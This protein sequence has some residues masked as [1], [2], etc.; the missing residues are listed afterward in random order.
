MS[1]FGTDESATHAL[2]CLRLATSRSPGS[3]GAPLRPSRRVDAALAA[4]YPFLTYY[5]QETR[6]YALVALLGMLV[7]AFVLTFV[8]GRRASLPVSVSPR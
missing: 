5:S 1:V 6:M 4:I 7:T 3:A 2:S 8:Y